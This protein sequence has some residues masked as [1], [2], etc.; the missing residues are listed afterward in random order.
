VTGIQEWTGEVEGKSVHE[1][2]S[3]VETLARVSG[4]MNC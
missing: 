1:F 4:W 2:F 3:Q